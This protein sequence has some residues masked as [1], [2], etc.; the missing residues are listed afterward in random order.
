MQVYTLGEIS[1]RIIPEPER[2]VKLLTGSD[3]RDL[4]YDYA[5][6]GKAVND[7]NKELDEKV[8]RNSKSNGSIF[9]GEAKIDRK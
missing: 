2:E 4:L 1:K 5:F 8:G 3:R 9:F 7:L 6:R